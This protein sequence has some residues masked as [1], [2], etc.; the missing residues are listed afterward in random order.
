MIFGDYLP[1]SQAEQKAVRLFSVKW[2]EHEICD[3]LTLVHLSLE[4]SDC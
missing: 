2:E 4:F 1:Q 3:Q